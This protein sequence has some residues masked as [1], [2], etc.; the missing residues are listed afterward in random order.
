MENNVFQETVS[1]KYMDTEGNITE[2]TRKLE[3]GSIDE[4]AEIFANFLKASGFSQEWID[5]YIRLED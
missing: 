5:K 3:D 2:V 1:F 4:V